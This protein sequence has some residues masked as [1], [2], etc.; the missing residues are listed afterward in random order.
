MLPNL[1]M[2]ALQ[3]LEKD[4]G[5][6]GRLVC[7]GGHHHGDRLYDSDHHGASHRCGGESEVVR[8]CCAYILV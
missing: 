2:G 1:R 4:G 5:S 8:T 3:A 6:I 7:R